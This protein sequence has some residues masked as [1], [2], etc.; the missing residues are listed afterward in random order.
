MKLTEFIETNHKLI[1]KDWVKFART[2]VPWANGMDDKGLLDHAEEIL[3]AV[4]TDMRAPQSV[5]Q[6][7][8]KSKGNAADGALAKIGQKH[9]SDRLESGLDLNQLVSEYRAL[10]ASVLKLWEA[11]QPDGDDE[12]TRFNEAIDETLGKSTCRYSETVSATREQF[13][14]I[15]G[16]DLRNPLGAVIMGATILTE[17]ADP[18]HAKIAATI[19]NSAERMHRMVDDLLDLTRT[20]LGTGI[21]IEHE[22]VELAPLCRQVV[23]ELEAFHPGRQI[24]LQ[25]SGDLHGEWDGDRLAQVVSNLVANA[26]QYSSPD[27]P[28]DVVALEKGDEIILQVHNVGTPI[29]ESAFKTIFSPLARLHPGGQTSD[30]NSTG[31]GLGLFIA[32]EIVSSHGG[33]ISVTSTLEAGTT[34]KVTIPRS[35]TAKKPPKVRSNPAGDQPSESPAPA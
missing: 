14:G 32:S 2:M 3:T 26:L 33:T 20:R 31:L 22:P 24:H 4:V 35:P 23:S 30:P 8:E 29:P 28:V 34:F 13:L 16:H 19:L 18:E 25:L 6:Q 21:P 5:R 15:L 1:L 27:T 17:S 10:R 12:M 11:T 7:S 9:A